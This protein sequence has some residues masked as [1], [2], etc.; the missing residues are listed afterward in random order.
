MQPTINAIRQQLTL[1]G[2]DVISTNTLEGRYYHAENCKLG[3][4]IA[5]LKDQFKHEALKVL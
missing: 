3:R 2:W 4:T 1:Q 5:G